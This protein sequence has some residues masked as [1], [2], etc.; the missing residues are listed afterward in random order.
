MPKLSLLKNSSITLKPIAGE[1]KEVYTFLNGYL[2][3][4]EDLRYVE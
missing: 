3:E 4:S 1:D 2:S